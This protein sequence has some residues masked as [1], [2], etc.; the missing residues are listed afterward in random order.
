MT[1]GTDFRQYPVFFVLRFSDKLYLPVLVGQKI[2]SARMNELKDSVRKS[3]RL[4][5]A[6]RDPRWG[7]D[8]RY[9]VELAGT[10]ANAAAVCAL[11]YKTAW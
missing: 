2:V 5:T 8:L 3:A 1:P 11:R 7:N 10:F 9:K 4:A 6:A